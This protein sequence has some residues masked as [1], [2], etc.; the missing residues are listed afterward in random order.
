M[1]P[2]FKSNQ[3]EWESKNYTLSDPAL[4]NPLD[5]NAVYGL[6]LFD[7]SPTVMDVRMG[8]V[9]ALS[10]STDE[11]GEYSYLVVGSTARFPLFSQQMGDAGTVLKQRFIA[12]QVLNFDGSLLRTDPQASV[13]LAIRVDGELTVRS[14]AERQYELVNWNREKAGGYVGA[15]IGFFPY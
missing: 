2:Y 10:L 9:G 3:Q 8:F 5:Y 7:M 1:K 15:Y 6:E 12:S 13:G 11:V 4:G 14:R